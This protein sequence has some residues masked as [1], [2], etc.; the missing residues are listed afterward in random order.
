M[1]RKQ[2]M[3]KVV[4][5]SNMTKAIRHVRKKK[6]A[7]GIDGM[8]VFEVEHHIVQYYA[9]LKEKLL[10]GTYKPQPVKRVDIPKSDGGTRQL[11]IP[12][13][14]DRVIQQ[15]IRQ[16]IEPMIDPQFT[17]HSHGFRPGRSTHTAL[18]QCVRY[19]EAGY[20]VVVDCDLK[21]CFDTLNHDKMMYH[22][23]QFVPDKAI[24][25]FIRKS[26]KSG[27]IDMHQ[28][29]AE[30]EAGAVQGGVIS[31]LLCNIYL[32]ELDKALMQR[33]HRFVRYADDFMIFVKSRRAAERVMKSITAFIETDLKL[34]VNAKKSSVGSPT[35][36]KF[37]SCLIMKTRGGCR[38]RP[39]HAAKRKF[40][41]TLKRLTNRN[42][43]G[44]FT[45][46][47]KQINQVTRG[48][49]N[50]FGQGFVKTFVKEIEPWLHHRLRQLILKR[51]KTPR[52]IITYLK[53][54]GLD[55]DSAKRIGFSRKKHWRLSK[56]PEMHIAINTEKLHKWGVVSLPTL[57]ENAYARY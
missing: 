42:R 4:A 49:I 40:K 51:W 50:Y 38:F 26:L 28:H 1:Y 25:T 32:H 14:R 34:T 33:G 46:I 18:K 2:L 52:T 21:R 5:Q 15:A 7:P 19:Y 43:S 10:N 31:P 3:E 8:T 20:K 9:P 17:A 13:A 35:R 48:W 23:E 22:F 57:A 54:Y 30:T 47:A 41:R 55:T 44:T 27:V 39:T 24:C 37:L 6:G 11:G 29:F 36:L 16:V 53:R 56:T 12:T 45:D